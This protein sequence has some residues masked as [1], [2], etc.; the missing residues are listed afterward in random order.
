MIWGFAFP[1]QDFTEKLKMLIVTSFSCL[2]KDDSDTELS[3]AQCGLQEAVPG[4]LQIKLKE[5]SLDLGPPC[6]LLVLYDLPS[7]SHQLLRPQ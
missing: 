6:E 2:A 5:L 4:G 1:S 7:E 3:R